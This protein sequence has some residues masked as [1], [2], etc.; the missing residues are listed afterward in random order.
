MPRSP[1]RETEKK[2]LIMARGYVDMQTGVYEWPGGLKPVKPDGS[3]RISHRE[4]LR[5][6]GYSENQNSNGKALFT[7]PFFQRE[8]RLE[9]A[10]REA[11]LPLVL[12]PD[13]IDLLNLGRQMVKEVLIR[14]KQA[15]DGF[16]NGQL[17]HYGPNILKLGLELQ[18]K[19]RLALE[20]GPNKVKPGRMQQFNTYIGTVV[21]KMS[22]EEREEFVETTQQSSETRLA[23]IQR[24]I[25]AQSARE[26]DCGATVVDAQSDPEPP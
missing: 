5:H 13:P 12:E 14:L 17:L 16:T 7:D 10:R 23:L 20:E 21:G 24:L 25:D 9:T 22:P 15:P 11:Q 2:L 6:A 26:E 18:L 1:R 8:V 19:E 4:L 3:P